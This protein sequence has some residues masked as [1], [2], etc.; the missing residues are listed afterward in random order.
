MRARTWQVAMA[1]ALTLGTVAPVEAQGRGNGRDRD[2]DRYE[3]AERRR[4]RDDDRRTAERRRDRDDR[5]EDRH[6]DDRYGRSAR[7][8]R[9]N[10]PAFCRSGSGHPVFGWDWCRDRGWDRSNDRY[11]VRWEERGWEDVIF[12]RTDRRDRLDRTDIGDVLGSIIFGRLDT[13]RRE[14]HSPDDYLGRFIDT[15]RGRE[16][17]I[18][19]GGIPLARLIDRDGDRRVDAVF[20]AER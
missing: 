8:E 18:T 9:G 2:E 13:R 19:A 16:L 20:L 3:R 4:D 1:I 15:A 6:R 14:L 11:P 7:Q 17:W 5:Y 12:G 10:G